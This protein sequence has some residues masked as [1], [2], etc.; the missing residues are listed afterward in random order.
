MCQLLGPKDSDYIGSS[1][2][3]HFLVIFMFIQVN[4]RYLEHLFFFKINLKKKERIKKDDI[5][6]F[7]T[8]LNLD[9]VLII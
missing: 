1:D 6:I 7:S 3:K 5:V 4:E 9:A 8:L 2:Q